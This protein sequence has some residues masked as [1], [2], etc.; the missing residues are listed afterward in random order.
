MSIITK[1]LLEGI[2]GIHFIFQG[3]FKHCLAILKAHFHFYHLI[4][5][6][7]KKRNGIHYNEYYKVD[8]IL[9]RYFIKNSKVF[10]NKN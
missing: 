5:R 1:S 8:S 4:S 3:K 6:N 9:Y 10:E 7:L 2:A